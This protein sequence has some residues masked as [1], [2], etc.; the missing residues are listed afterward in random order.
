MAKN[1]KMVICKNCNAPIPENT[2]ICPSCGAKNKKPFYKR[3][4]FIILAVIVV[5]GIIRIIGGGSGNKGEKFKW[6]DMELSNILP[7]PK[8]N[9][10]RILSNSDEHLSIYIH[11]T[12]KDEYNDYLDEC[13]SI[14]FTVES[15]KSENNYAAYNEA[16]YKLSL[17]YNDRDDE[18]H[19]ALDAPMEM[20]TL[21]WPTSEIASLLPIPK[22]TVGTISRESSDGFY[23]YVGE[24]S[25]DDYDTYVNECSEKGFSVDYE[26][27]DTYYRADNADGY[28]ISLSYQGNR[29]MTIEIEKPEET[30]PIATP[31]TDN[32]SAS[33]DNDALSANTSNTAPGG[34]TDLVDGMRPEFKEAMDSYEAFYDEYCN[35]MKKY[36]DNPTD[37]EL[38]AKYA[39]MMSK[40]ADMSEKF[41]AWNEGELNNVE[42]NYYLEVNN[43]VTQKLLEIAQ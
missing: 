8:S 42:L 30:A 12:S 17:W 2:K 28:H 24:I 16:G 38:L 31:N 35:F 33:E 20:G 13:Q 26:K 25:K 29:V 21:Q 5:I 10:G 11:K 41:D 6:T 9:V 18:L 23:I 32:P 34:A 4:W 3:A 36:A 37:I 19:I 39:D 15:D 1:P 40:A 14:G 43:R 22:S 27:G 7:E